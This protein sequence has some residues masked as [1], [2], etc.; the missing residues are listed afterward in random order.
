MAI[1]PV[2]L[3][4]AARERYLSYAL[5]VITS[6]ALPDVRDGLK[7]V[8]RRILY[9][10]AV[11]LG[12]GPD[13]RYRKSAAVVGEV[14]GKFHPHGDQAIY[15]AM[16][17][18]AQDFSLLHPLVDGQ[19][20]FGSLDG[21]PPAAMRYTEARLTAL[22]RELTV[23]I[24][25]DTVD[26]RPTYDG[27]REEPIVLPAQFPQMLVNGS[28][29][30]AVG[31]ATR[32]PPH[33][34]GEVVD[35]TVALIDDPAIE[36][37]GLVKHLVAPD[38]P[39]GGLILSTPSELR[40]IYETGQGS[41]RI[42]ATWR[43][44][45]ENRRDQVI[46]TS[47]P[48]GQ[49]KAKL[50]ERIGAEVAAKKLPQVVDVRDE[51]TEEVRIVLE[52]KQGAS[53]EAVMA[54]L[55]KHT[56][57]EGTFPVNLTCLVPTDGGVPAPMRLDLKE[58]LRH[59]SKFRFDTTRRRFEFQLKKLRE[60]IHILEGFA[61]VFDALDEVIAIIRKSEGK[62][63]AAEKLMKRFAL[64]EIQT[65]AILSLRLYHLARLEIQAIRDEL[66]EK[67][68]EAHRI[69]EILGSGAALW[70]VVRAELLAVKQLYG[71]PRR[72]ELGTPAAATLT[73]Q[74]ETY[75]VDEDTFVV[76]TRD[77]WFKRQSSF[78]D[79]SRIRIREDDTIG[80]L[81]KA[82]TRSTLTFL[83]NH[84]GAYVLRVD[85]VPQTT[86]YG[87]PIQAR[88]SFDDGEKIV[89]VLSHDARHRLVAEGAPRGEDE[90]DPPWAVAI[91]ERGRVLRFAL[92]A[93]AEPSNKSGRRFAKLDDGDVVL[94]VLPCDGTETVSVATRGGNALAFPVA[95][96]PVLKAPGKGVTGIK[97]KDDEAGVLAFELVRDPA[98]GAKVTTTMGREVVVS[99]KAYGG[100]RG[101]RGAAVI[102]RG[103]FEGW[104]R[105]PML[106]LGP[107]KE[108]DEAPAATTG[109]EE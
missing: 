70:G 92:A 39:T 31:M 22:A 80:W 97:I 88:F 2:P 10:M 1:E 54:W 95:E 48:Y 96:V 82:G 75:I 27:Q 101:A 13:G 61:I 89:G 8:Q 50:I 76:V 23:E 40:T 35:A 68:A 94:A 86:G 55:F 12:L 59:W 37:E 74:E 105:E 33:N 21:D 93:H 78:T 103:G 5:S 30:I 46:V 26:F 14:M 60:R 17:R 38:F 100:A 44:E 71:R 64:S 108:V 63:D 24:D 25:Q 79:L 58:I 52:L 15:D 56:P 18:L 77:G 11:E 85:D 57:L 42:R 34:L 7:P 36:V 6:R 9:T 32:I 67:L 53:A 72:S 28:E 47:I 106:W 84:G 51:S 104:A 49:N 65:D 81:V 87:E 19:G 41:V 109:E 102:K 45:H 98:D 43:H 69:E 20:N 3:H 90:P 16:V 29:G 83:S 4:E 62:R 91:T 107:G 99:H 66:A 73:Y